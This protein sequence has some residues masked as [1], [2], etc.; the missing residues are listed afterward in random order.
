MEILLILA[1]IVGAI[2]IL[3]NPF[4]GLLATVA[5]IP[6]ALIPATANSFLGTFTMITPIKIIGA[7]TFITALLKQLTQNKNWD[8]FKQ[9][10]FKYYIWFLVYI[11]FSGFTQPSSFTRENFTTFISML[12]LGFSIIAL[13][14]SPKRLKILLWIAM[15]SIGFIGASSLLNYSTLQNS[16]TRMQGS[17]YGPN[18]FAIGILPFIG[19]SFYT[20]KSSRKKIHKLSAFILLI[21]LISSLVITV[22][23]GGLLGLTGMAFFGFLKSKR[24]AQSLLILFLGILILSL[25]MP[26]QVWERFHKTQIKDIEIQDGTTRSTERRLLLAKAGWG[27]FLDNPI[28]GIGV[29]NYY[30]ECMKYQ[31]VHPGRAHTMYLEIM[32][33]LGIIG[34]LLFFLILQ[35]TFKTLKNI[36]KT[37]NE[38]SGYAMGL[39]IGLIGFLTAALFLHAQ[40]DKN[41]WLLI[42]LTAALDNIYRTKNNKEKV[43]SGKR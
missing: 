39:S 4:I 31:P 23:R 14:D 35:A 33:E 19:I 34:I 20:I 42:F 43:V 29:G 16:F 38:L 21:I 6:Q 22:S 7:L 30:W 26:N 15:L 24:K 17:A 18:Y 32:A 5:L 12:F 1:G 25:T 10:I 36:Y 11:F 27:I 2:T 3:I 37:P 13:V 40:Q 41:L 28:L 9:P 8:Q